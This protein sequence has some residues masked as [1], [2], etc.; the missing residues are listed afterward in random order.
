[1]FILKYLL[2][3][4]TEYTTWIAFFAVAGSFG[5]ELSEAQQNSIA[6]LSIILFGA[7]EKT[8]LKYIKTKK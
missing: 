4:F 5:L 1:M 8:I 2:P 3:R 6:V 7:P